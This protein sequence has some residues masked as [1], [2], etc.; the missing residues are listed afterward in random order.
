MYH[1]MFVAIVAAIIGLFVT[2]CDD[3]LLP[4]DPFDPNPPGNGSGNE[5]DTSGVRDPITF[6]GTIIGGEGAF[7]N[8][9]P[10]DAHLVVVWHLNDGTDVIGAVGQITSPTT[11][12]ITLSGDVPMN[13]RYDV[14][15][16]DPSFAIGTL[17]I[18]RGDITKD[19]EELEIVAVSM[20]NDIIFDT[21]EPT[22]NPWASTFLDRFPRGYQA[23]A[24][25]AGGPVDAIYYPIGSTDLPMHILER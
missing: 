2:S 25:M 23:A 22:S 13:A 18:V 11:Y 19:L 6:S 5:W 24:W 14:G 10:E 17:T 21:N 3:I 8:G 4:T 16:N 12:T 20:F 15:A 7:A 9:V 1:R